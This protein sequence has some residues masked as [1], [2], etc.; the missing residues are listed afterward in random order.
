MLHVAFPVSN[1]DILNHLLLPEI[2][3][4][5]KTH[6]FLAFFQRKSELKREAR[7]VLEEEKQ[8]E[9]LSMLLLVGTNTAEWHPYV[10][11][12]L[13]YFLLHCPLWLIHTKSCHV[14]TSAALCKHS[15]N[16]C[17]WKWWLPSHF[18][19]YTCQSLRGRR[20]NLNCMPASTYT[21]FL[22]S[23]FPHSFSLALGTELGIIFAE[24]GISACWASWNG[25]SIYW[26][27]NVQP[28]GRHIT[29]FLFL[30]NVTVCTSAADLWEAFIF[31]DKSWPYSTVSSL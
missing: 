11:L 16:A 5:E 21:S 4:K 19:S 20:V 15:S 12:N 27:S 18:R 28:S 31:R 7:K 25:F 17:L 30:S 13:P 10:R 3:L 1:L 24:R 2:S 26:E 6:F 8:W 29:W 22:C 23:W 9:K 14:P